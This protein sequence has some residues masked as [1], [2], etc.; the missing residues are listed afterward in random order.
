MTGEQKRALLLMCL[1]L[2]LL[3]TDKLHHLNAGTV[4]VCV[5]VA[6]FLPGVK[7][8]DEKR[9]ASV[10]FAPLFFIM[11]CMCIGSAGGF[12]K[13]TGRL[14]GLVLPLF[15]EAGATSAAVYAYL[16]G[17]GMNFLLTPLAATSTLTAPITELGMQMCLDPRLLY[18][19]FSMAWIT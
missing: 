15:S 1:M 13:A 9:I 2:A 19:A 12:L 5:T 14:A 18:F 6:S 10:N 3:A 16:V 17:V 4:L 11:G 8:M 7:L